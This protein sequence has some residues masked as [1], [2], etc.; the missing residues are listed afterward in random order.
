MVRRA[1]HRCA[2]STYHVLCPVCHH[3]V[4]E[5]KTKSFRVLPK[6]I[7]M[8]SRVNESEIV[9][10]YDQGRSTHTIE[11]VGKKPKYHRHDE[12]KDV[13][14]RAHARL[15]HLRC[16]DLVHRLADGTKLD[17][18]RL[19]H[20]VNAVEP[21]FAPVDGTAVKSVDGPF[22]D[23][24]GNWKR[25]QSKLA[26][27]SPSSVMKG[28]AALIRKLPCQ[29]R[30]LI[31]DIGCGRMFFIMDVAD[32]MAQ[33]NR[34]TARLRERFAVEKLPLTGTKIQLNL[35]H[36]GGRTYIQRF[37]DVPAQQAEKKSK[38]V[39][40]KPKT[41]KERKAA[42]Q[43]ALSAAQSKDNSEN[44]VV[45]DLVDKKNSFFAVKT[46][47][48][49]IVDVAF[50]ETSLGPKWKLGHQTAPFDHWVSQVR[51]AD[52]SELQVLTD[53]SIFFLYLIKTHTNMP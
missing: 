26:S 37:A 41:R 21:T 30:C 35:V 14:H 40:G 53:V 47:G 7:I 31:S 51:N 25:Q 11:I 5:T 1:H 19:F 42:E 46:D 18:S 16:L 29:V 43:A 23:S 9:Y 10:K 20:V 22:V 49:G 36:L 8:A 12:T 28:L 48:V 3:L 2:L 4:D 33:G 6:D 39:K 45:F 44:Q 34:G 13:A 38:A 32:W 24:E 17:A 52:L 50:D 27:S 15:V